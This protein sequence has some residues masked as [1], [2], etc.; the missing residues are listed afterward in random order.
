MTGRDAWWCESTDMTIQGKLNYWSCNGAGKRRHL[1]SDNA[2]SSWPL[3]NWT[4]TRASIAWGFEGCS[5]R[6]CKE[7]CS[8]CSSGTYK[9][10]SNNQ[11]VAG[12]NKSNR[13]SMIHLF[14]HSYSNGST[15]AHIDCF[16]IE[17][18]SPMLPWEVMEFSRTWLRRYCFL[19]I[20]KEFCTFIHCRW[21]TICFIQMRRDPRMILSGVL[22]RLSRIPRHVMCINCEDYLVRYQH[23]LLN[24][25]MIPTY[26]AGRHVD[27]FT[28]GIP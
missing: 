25:N 16:D 27:W 13:L 9:K 11:I 7:H 2:I 15:Y 26:W 1:S 24:R 4:Y 20:G 21:R 12:H 10:I 19:P 22:A 6:A 3:A 23:G 8:A 17:Y 14:I 5:L 18:E 28:W